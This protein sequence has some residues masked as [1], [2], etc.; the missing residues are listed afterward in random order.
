M[1]FPFPFICICL[2]FVYTQEIN[3]TSSF[4][5]SYI[6]SITVSDRYSKK[7]E[8][9]I[10]VRK[11]ILPRVFT[12]LASSY[13]VFVKPCFHIQTNTVL[14]CCFFLEGVCFRSVKCNTVSCSKR[15]GLH[16]SFVGHHT[17]PHRTKVP[18]HQVM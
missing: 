8:K 3:Y 1:K 10:C 2:L 17:L 13:P 14:C 12:C 18:P 7:R 6:C 11:N 15:E 9:A 4:L 16:H 5:L